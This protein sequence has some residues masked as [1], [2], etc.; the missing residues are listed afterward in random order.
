VPPAHSRLSKLELHR[1]LRLRICSFF[2]VHLLFLHHL[3]L[4]LLHC[5]SE[6]YFLSGHRLALHNRL[7][8][9]LSFSSSSLDFAVR[10][11]SAALSASVL[12]SAL[13]VLGRVSFAPW[14]EWESE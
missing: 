6:L 11:A 1:F 5:H 3:L 13:L 2:F 7:L 14:W 9:D 10:L 4:L 12:D 8:L